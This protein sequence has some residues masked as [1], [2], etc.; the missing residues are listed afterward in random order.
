MAIS[1]WGFFSIV[2]LWRYT[3]LNAKSVC[4]KLV[5]LLLLIPQLPS[6]DD[7]VLSAVGEVTQ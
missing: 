5:F 3:S 4:S 1:L 7:S 6:R 2:C